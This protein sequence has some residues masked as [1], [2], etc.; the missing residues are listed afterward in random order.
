MVR[1]AGCGDTSTERGFTFVVEHAHKRQAARHGGL[2]Q[3]GA[4]QED[5]TRFTA[6]VGQL[7][8]PADKRMLAACYLGHGGMI[9]G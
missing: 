7:A 6:P 5:F 8:A 1:T 4:V 3:M 9:R 2:D